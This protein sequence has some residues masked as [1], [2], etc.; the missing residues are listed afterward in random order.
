MA[1]NILP[2]SLPF[3]FQLVVGARV[4]FEGLLVPMKVAEAP[5]L[6]EIKIAPVELVEPLVEIVVE[7]VPNFVGSLVEIGPV[8]RESVAV[9]GIQL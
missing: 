2:S 7:S 8:F 4:K 9:G 6:V 1:D 5:T 3:S